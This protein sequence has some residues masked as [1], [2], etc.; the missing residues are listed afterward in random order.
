MLS[1]SILTNGIRLEAFILFHNGMKKRRGSGRRR[2]KKFRDKSSAVMS[3]L[4][5]PFRFPRFF[6]LSTRITEYFTTGNCPHCC[7]LKHPQHF[8]KI[9]GPFAQNQTRIIS[10]HWNSITKCNATPSITEQMQR[11]SRAIHFGIR[12]RRWHS[13]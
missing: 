4:S 2:S 1:M 6:P 9:T 13:N 12:H 7:K 10:G 11:H 8:I 5:M 3:K